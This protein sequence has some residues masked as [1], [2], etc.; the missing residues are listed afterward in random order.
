MVFLTIFPVVMGLLVLVPPVVLSPESY[1]QYLNIFF[2]FLETILYI[3]P[4]PTVLTIVTILIGLQLFRIV[5][6][7]IKMIWDILPVV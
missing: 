7:F 6:S 5:I 2:G 3:L 4:A 1:E